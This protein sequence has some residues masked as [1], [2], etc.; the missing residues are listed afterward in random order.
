MATSV[1]AIVLVGL[2]HPRTVGRPLASEHQDRVLLSVLF[3][4]AA[5]FG[6]IQPL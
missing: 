6:V 2:L 1:R 3:V 4:P 5:L